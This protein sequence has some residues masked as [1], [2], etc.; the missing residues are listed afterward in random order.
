MVIELI[1]LKY[2]V[3]LKREPPGR[4]KRSKRPIKGRGLKKETVKYYRCLDLNASIEVGF[5]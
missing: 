5:D 1:A 2:P 4:E 3:S